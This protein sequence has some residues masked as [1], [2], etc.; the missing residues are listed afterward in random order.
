MI[1]FPLPMPPV[2]RPAP[3]GERLI[4]AVVLVGAIL[5]LIVAAGLLER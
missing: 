1:R 5:L 4:G 3:H 2:K